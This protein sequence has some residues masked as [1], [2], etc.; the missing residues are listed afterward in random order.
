MDPLVSYLDRLK[1]LLRSRGRT[2]DDAEDLI[3]DAFVRMQTYCQQGRKVHKPEAFL[4]RTALRLDSNAHRYARRRPHT[5]VA[6]D[7]LLLDTSPSPEELVEAEQCLAR[8]RARLDR[9]SPQLREVFFL[10]RLE[11]L[12]RA[13]IAERFGVSVST[14]EK[15]IASA[16]AILMEEVYR[17]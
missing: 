7:L 9:V 17:T 14:V 13:Q 2:Q 10:H 12:S 16:V 3:Q 11:G 6:E 4:V 5:E 1:K 8:M 15:Q